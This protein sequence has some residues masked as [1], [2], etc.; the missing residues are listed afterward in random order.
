VSDYRYDKIADQANRPQRE[1]G[2]GLIIEESTSICPVCFD[3]DC[4]MHIEP[5][6]SP[7]EVV[8]AEVMRQAPVIAAARACLAAWDASEDV[9]P[10]VRMALSDLS[11]ALA[12]FDRLPF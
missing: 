3:V 2:N 5:E 10:R 9:P 4:R 12:K 7:A 11:D 6:P 1:P 8:M